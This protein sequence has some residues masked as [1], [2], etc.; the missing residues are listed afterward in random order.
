[1]LKIRKIN[2]LLGLG[3]LCPAL[4]FA[5]AATDTAPKSD[6]S[7]PTGTSAG[8][9]NRTVTQVPKDEW[10]KKIKEIVSEPIC[11]GFVEDASISERLKEQKISY[12]K[13]VTLIPPIA[14]KCEKKYYDSIPAMI[15]EDNAS[16][17]GR[18]IGECIGA[19]FAVNYLYPGSGTS[20][21]A[22]STSSK[23]D[24]STNGSSKSSNGASQKSGQ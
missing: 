18:M 22:D 6:G 23:S 9:S 11:K 13:C 21:S 1:M 20:A 16:K 15:T 24:N 8:A 2:T 4:T 17:W 12:E 14:E 19:D 7:Q 10:L 3:I 5:A